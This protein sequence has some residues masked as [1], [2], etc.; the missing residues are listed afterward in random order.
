MLDDRDRINAA[1]AGIREDMARYYLPDARAFVGSMMN[2]SLGGSLR[3]DD[4]D[5]EELAGLAVTLTLNTFD[6]SRGASFKTWLYQQCRHV[7]RDRKVE[8]GMFRSS[9]NRVFFLQDGDDCGLLTGVPSDRRDPATSLEDA[10]LAYAILDRYRGSPADSRQS[11]RGR[12]LYERI[13]NDRTHQEIGELLGISD[14][15]SQW[16]YK[17]TIERLRRVAARMGAA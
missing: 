4:D 1:I 14:S 9:E 13:W 10:D 8:M 16:L 2:L 7:V 5:I 3:V 6:P 11:R 12:I 17:R 15:R